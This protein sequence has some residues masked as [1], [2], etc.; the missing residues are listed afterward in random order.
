MSHIVPYSETSSTINRSL[1]VPVW[2]IFQTYSS[3]HIFTVVS[4]CMVISFAIQ[5]KAVTD[6]RLY[7]VV[8]HLSI[9]KLV[10]QGKEAECVEG[11]S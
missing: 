6:D 10:L 4:T 1:Q 2:R 3:M 5:C 11:I 8:C 9:G 7:N